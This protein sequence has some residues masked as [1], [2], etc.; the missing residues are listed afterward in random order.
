MIQHIPINGDFV[1]AKNLVE[2]LI[3]GEMVGTLLLE[4]PML[5]KRAKYVDTADPWFDILGLFLMFK[6]YKSS[7]D[8]IG[9]LVPFDECI[10]PVSPPKVTTAPFLVADFTEKNIVRE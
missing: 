10:I 1:V 5:P 2:N 7:R 6:K 8:D 3:D 4:F 9:K